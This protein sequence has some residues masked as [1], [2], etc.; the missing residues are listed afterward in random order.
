MVLT[1]VA[2]FHIVLVGMNEVFN[3]I[4]L[5]DG[6]SMKDIICGLTFRIEFAI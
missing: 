6:F 5:L 2:R 4:V 1:L 3:N